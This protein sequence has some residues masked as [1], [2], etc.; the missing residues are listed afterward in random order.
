MERLKG[1]DPDPGDPRGYLETM[2]TESQHVV[3][4]VGRMKALLRNVES[5]QGCPTT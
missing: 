1:R 4:M 5:T 3:D 2:L